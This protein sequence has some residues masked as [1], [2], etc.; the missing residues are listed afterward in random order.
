MKSPRSQDLKECPRCHR[1]R[2]PSWFTKAVQINGRFIPVHQPTKQ[3]LFMC[4]T[5]LH[6]R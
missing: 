5:C 2:H 1:L 4:F 3:S 6:G